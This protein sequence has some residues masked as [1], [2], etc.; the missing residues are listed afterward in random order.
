MHGARQLLFA[1][2]FALQDIRLQR[3]RPVLVVEIAK[4]S[5]SSTPEDVGRLAKQVCGAASK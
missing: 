4:P 2:L 5:P 3:G 1:N